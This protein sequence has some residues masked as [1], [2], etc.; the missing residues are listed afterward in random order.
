MFSTAIER[1]MLSDAISEPKE[2]SCADRV[3]LKTLLLASAVFSALA[4]LSLATGCATWVAVVLSCTNLALM[5]MMVYGDQI[6]NCLGIQP[7]KG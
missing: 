2:N 7:K 3:T 1:K 4:I 6:A 5:I